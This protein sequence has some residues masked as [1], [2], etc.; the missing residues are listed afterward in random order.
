MHSLLENSGAGCHTWT[1]TWALKFDAGYWVGG[2]FKIHYLSRTRVHQGEP[3]SCCHCIRS[4][5]LCHV[6]SQRAPVTRTTG[7]RRCT[8]TGNVL[9]KVLFSVSI[10]HIRKGYLFCTTATEK[11]C[12]WFFRKTFCD[13]VYFIYV[14]HFTKH[15]NPYNSV[16]KYPGR[17]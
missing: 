13:T 10:F 9:L 8:P 4:P 12:I 16:R 5:R 14:L 2:I 15:F 1:D 7:G 11:Y 6:Q 17:Y 3:G